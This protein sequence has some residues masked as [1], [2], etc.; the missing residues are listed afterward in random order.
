MKAAIYA[1]VSTKDRQ[2][3]ENQLAQLRDY[4][5]K[6]GFEIHKE[7]IDH[8]SG[9]NPGR[10]QF[11]ALFQAGHQRQFDVVL[12]WALD[13][14]SREGA[15]ETINY[16]YRLEE[17]GVKYISFTEPYIN[18]LGIFKDAIISLL[19]TLAKQ[20][21]VRISERVKAGLDTARKKGKRLGRKPVAPIDRSKIIT[22]HLA[23]PDLSVRKLAEQIKFNYGTVN[24]TLSLYRAGKCDKDGF[25]YERSLC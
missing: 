11:K 25:L 5:R 10:E 3:T 21:K 15:R 12:F 13:R 17:S 6:Q 24:K 14:F 23:D 16:L 19:A 2:E 18:S 22:A 4:C 7:Y 20:E 1:R 9:G 8:E